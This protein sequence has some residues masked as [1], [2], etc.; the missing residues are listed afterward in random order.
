MTHEEINELEKLLFKL[1]EE[2]YFRTTKQASE[3][4]ILQGIKT[5]CLKKRLE[6]I[7]ADH[8]YSWLSLAVSILV[9]LATIAVAVVTN[10]KN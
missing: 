3:E 6:R 4:H 1:K 9:L 2:T 8:K 10:L 7:K 5:F